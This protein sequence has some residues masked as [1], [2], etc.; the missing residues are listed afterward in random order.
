MDLHRGTPAAAD[1]A[2]GADAA[3]ADCRRSAWR[4]R[5]ARRRRSRRCRTSWP[6][7]RPCTSR[8][9]RTRRGTQTVAVARV[10]PARPGCGRC[11]TSPPGRCPTGPRCGACWP[12]SPPS[13]SRTC[14]SS[15]DR[16]PLRSGSSTR[17]RRSSTRVS[18]RRPASSASGSSGHPEGHPD[19]ADD[20]LYRALVAKC[21]IARERGLDLHLVTQFA[22][23]RRADRRVGARDPGHGRR[24][25]RARR[26]A[27]PHLADPAAAVRPAVRRGRVAEGAPAAG[28]RRAQARDLARPPPRRHPRRPRGR[29]GRRP[30]QPAAGRALLP[31]RRAR[32]HRGVGVRHPRRPV[33]G[34]RPRPPARDRA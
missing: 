3:G 8:S 25:A 21:R 28:R 32:V 7:G 16:W 26:A 18:W 11:R 12:T 30:R 6:P 2:V 24:R 17:R 29:R 14:W 4:S 19:V 5:H 1:D 9:C 34:R 27:R 10:G 23:A 31:V 15:P 20:E 33:R 13:A 22:F